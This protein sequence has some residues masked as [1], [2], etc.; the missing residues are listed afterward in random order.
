MESPTIEL[1]TSEYDVYLDSNSLW[2]LRSGPCDVVSNDRGVPF[3]LHVM[4]SDVEDLPSD[5]KEH[6]FSGLDFTPEN[7]W[8]DIM[9][10]CVIERRLPQYD[11]AAIRTGQYDS[12][13][14]LWS[15][16]IRIAES[17]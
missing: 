14:E 5:R 10:F 15:A 1:S 7:H 13:G 9:G 12:R 8:L 17:E 16:D 3:F 11:I 4:P 6:G 2:Y